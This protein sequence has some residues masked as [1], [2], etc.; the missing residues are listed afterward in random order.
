VRA[1]PGLQC[2][3]WSRTSASRW[4]TDDTARLM[5]AAD[6]ASGTGAPNAPRLPLRRA[7]CGVR[8]DLGDPLNPRTPPAL[9]QHRSSLNIDRYDIR[10]A[11]MAM[12]ASW[13]I[14]S[15]HALLS[16]SSIK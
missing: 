6:A 7:V 14:F 4:L 10:R 15:K 2:S 9:G 8:F 11:T 3:T 5:F 13:S 12:R 16:V 1:C